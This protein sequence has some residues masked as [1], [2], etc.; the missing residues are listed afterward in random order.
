M[1]PGRLN[2]LLLTDLSIRKRRPEGVSWCM[3]K[4]AI[5]L[6]IISKGI[7]HTTATLQDGRH[8]HLLSMPSGSSSFAGQQPPNKE[9]RKTMTHTQSKPLTKMNRLKKSKTKFPNVGN[10][11]KKKKDTDRP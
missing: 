1:Q 7:N 4:N 9:D 10:P 6:F 3:Y 5:M 11:T 8:T 2:Y